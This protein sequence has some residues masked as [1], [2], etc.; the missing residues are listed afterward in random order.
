MWEENGNQTKKSIGIAGNN[1]VCIVLVPIGQEIEFI[2][3][4]DGF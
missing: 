1:Y 3:P 4:S 2:L